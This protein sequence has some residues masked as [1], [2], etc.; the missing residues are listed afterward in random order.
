MKNK[1]I[2][3]FRDILCTFYCAVYTE[4]S[5]STL[6]QQNLPYN[7]TNNII[8]LTLFIRIIQLLCEFSINVQAAIQKCN[9]D[10]NFKLIWIKVLGWQQMMI[11][12]GTIVQ[13]KCTHLI[14]IFISLLRL[15]WWC[16]TK[17]IACKRKE[18]DLIQIYCLDCL[19]SQ[20][21]FQEMEI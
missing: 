11:S 4:C 15:C 17:P 13:S 5:S 2:D 19:S 16:L 21:V 3:C 12:Q 6:C 8:L 7:Q 20:I 1:T 18:M 10:F 14:F 9:V